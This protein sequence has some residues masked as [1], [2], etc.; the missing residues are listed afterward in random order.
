MRRSIILFL[1]AVLVSG[2]RFGDSGRGVSAKPSEVH[3]FAGV[4]SAPVPDLTPTGYTIAGFD[5][6]DEQC[7]V[8]FDGIVELAKNSRYASSSIATAN[9]QAALIM[10]AVDAA[11]K[12]IAI[13]AASSE[14]ARKLIDGYAAEYAFSPYALEVRQLVVDALSAY[15]ADS[16]TDEAVRTLQALPPGDAFC[17]ANNIVRNYAKICTIANVEALARQAVANSKIGKSDSP[18]ANPQRTFSPAAASRAL[19]RATAEQLTSFRRGLALP[20]YTAG[21]P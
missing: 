19:P 16:K 10:A 1:L 15:R 14:L 21:K 20:N 12:S 2:C 11:T 6:V 18:A 8:F 13:V 7:G 17:L 3:A 5:F 4:C 9:T